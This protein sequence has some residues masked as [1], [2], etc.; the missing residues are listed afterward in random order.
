M[1]AGKAIPAAAAATPQQ[2]ARAARR[3]C[4]QL[5]R[6]AAMA[7]A[8]SAACCSPHSRK[9]PS[10]RIQRLKQN[11]QHKTLRQKVIQLL[12]HPPTR[13]RLRTR[14]HLQTLQQPNHHQQMPHHPTVLQKGR[15]VVMLVVLVLVVQTLQHPMVG[16]LLVGVQHALQEEEQA[17]VV[18]QQQGQTQQQV[19][20]QQQGQEEEQEV[21][22]LPH[23]QQEGQVLRCRRRKETAAR[24]PQAAEATRAPPAPRNLHQS[25]QPAL[26]TVIKCAAW[27]ATPSAKAASCARQMLTARTA[28]ADR[29]LG[30]SGAWVQTSCG[31]CAAAV[32][33]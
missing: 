6:P 29:I 12:S 16:L 17:A 28:S 1:Q 26:K 31:A 11:Q 30:H 19:Q 9:R 14:H 21:R 20:T 10:C 15:R 23:Q 2:K 5:A 24:L 13:H 4:K 25:L 8:T 27:G 18:A 33:F 32:S 3:L 22:L 7:G